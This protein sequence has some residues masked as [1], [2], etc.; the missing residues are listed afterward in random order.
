MSAF[1]ICDKR[2]PAHG[3]TISL[4]S[5]RSTSCAVLPFILLRTRCTD[6]PGGNISDKIIGRDVDFYGFLFRGRVFAGLDLVLDLGR[7][8]SS[9]C[10][11]KVRIFPERELAGLVAEP[12]ADGPASFPASVE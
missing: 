3:S 1:S 12:V 11:V 9:G 4:L 7:L 2:R 8:L 6:K 10:K 5:M